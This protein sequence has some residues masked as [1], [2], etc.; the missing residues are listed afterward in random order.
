[1]IPSDA[2]T[3]DG[4]IDAGYQPVVHS[5]EQIDVISFE[6][7]STNMVELIIDETHLNL[8]HC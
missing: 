3:I 2:A 1:M 8:K 7:V 5:T 6:I 4:L